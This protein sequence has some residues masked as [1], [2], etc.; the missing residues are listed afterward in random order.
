MSILFMFPGQGSQNAGML[1]ALPQ[2][3][4]V[5]RTMEEAG[6]A[7]NVDPL[8]LDTEQAL[9]STVATQL[10]LA[11]AGV[12]AARALIRQDA[13]PDMVAGLSIG[14]WPAAVAAGV[15]DFGDALRLVRLR[16]QL[17]EDAYPSGYGMAA[18][19]GLDEPQVRL[20][21]GDGSQQHQSAAH[22]THA[23][24]Q[25]RPRAEAIHQRAG[26]LRDSDESQRDRHQF[27]SGDK[28]GCAGDDLQIERR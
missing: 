17:M 9:G 18:I 26:A 13:A 21:C 6:D 14:A 12:A 11:I 7:L 24:G 1:H 5:A 10:C 8:G 27:Q 23:A 20:R 19:V 2:D 16:G 25:H 3:P 22:A 15:M 4:A 28:G